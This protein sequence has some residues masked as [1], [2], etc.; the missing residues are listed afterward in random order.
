LLAGV[1]A[2]SL[3]SAQETKD[4]KSSVRK[5][6]DESEYVM[7]DLDLSRVAAFYSGIGEYVK[8]YPMTVTDLKTN[9]SEK[10]VLMKM[11]IYY[12][13]DDNTKKKFYYDA[14][15]GR[16]EID[17]FI[18]FIEKYVIPNLNATTD[19]KKQKKIYVFHAKEIT[20]TYLISGK[21]RQL[22][23][24]LNFTEDDPDSY[25]FWTSTQVKKIT[26]L[27]DLLKKL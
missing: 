16:D 14:Y 12:Y 4:H 18:A 9:K 24:K 25:E 21:K 7:I 6:V 23:I 15:I 27:V 22:R 13:L 10:G 5:M 20:M 8:F 1:W 19:S 2:V 17:D 26:E 11:Y 3:L